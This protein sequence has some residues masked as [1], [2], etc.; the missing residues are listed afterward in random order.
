MKSFYSSRNLE[1][2]TDTYQ[3]SYT[4]LKEKTKTTPVHP[5]PPAPMNGLSRD[6][7]D[8]NYTQIG[9]ARFGA[10]VDLNARD[11]QAILNDFTHEG[12]CE[13]SCYP[14]VPMT[15]HADEFRGA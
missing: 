4:S 8:D 14:Q 2:I 9:M 10:Y 7:T 3:L 15:L 6:T 5:P 1:G 11:S 12:I 13:D